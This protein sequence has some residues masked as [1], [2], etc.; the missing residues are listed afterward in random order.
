M[1]SYEGSDVV[2]SYEGSDVWKGKACRIFIALSKEEC[3]RDSLMGRGCFLRTDESFCL[4]TN[5][6]PCDNNSSYY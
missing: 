2:R 6:T 5:G 3:V 1:Q 4:E